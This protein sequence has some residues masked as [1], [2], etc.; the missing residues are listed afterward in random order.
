MRRTIFA[1][2]TVVH[3][4]LVEPGAGICNAGTMTTNN[5]FG[6][7]GPF[8]DLFKRQREQAELIKRA[9]GPGYELQQR[10]KALEGPLAGMRDLQRTGTL[11]HLADLQNAGVLS[12]ARA[13]ATLHSDSIKAMQALASSSW[14]LALQKTAI[15]ISQEDLGILKTQK[16]LAGSTGPDVLK[17]AKTFDANR[18][19]LETMM[20]ASKW[21]EQFRTLSDRF[22]PSIAGIKVA[23]ESALMLDMMTLRASAEVVA[24][25]AVVVAAEQVLEAHRLFEAIGQADS[26]AQS[27]S[28]FAAF[29]SLMAAIFARF[30]ENTL[31]ELQGIGAVKLI[32]LFMLGVAIFQFAAPADMS[33]AEKKVVAEMKVEVETLQDK[34]DKILAANEAANEAYVSNLPRAELKRDAAIRREAQGNAQVLMRGATGMVL[35]VK[36]SQGKWRLVVYRDPLT[37]QLAE[38]WVYAPA[39]QL[40]DAP[41]K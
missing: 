35:A 40:L 1:R 6:P 11:A 26:P 2:C 4:M 13:T 33:P 31:K 18:S 28:L 41:V 16:L 37:D 10:L 17:L 38:G 22:A 21:T 12:S 32:E 14:M 19:I 8:N 15:G 36:Q 20:T 30:G 29:V 25:S 3:Q 24:K 5:P 23:A 27:A 34:L 39:V 7:G 9:L